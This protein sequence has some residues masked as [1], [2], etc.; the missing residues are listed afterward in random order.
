MHDD[1]VMIHQRDYR[2]EPKEHDQERSD[3][4][5]DKERDRGGDTGAP[6]SALGDP[7]APKNARGDS[8]KTRK[9]A[10]GDPDETRNKTQTQPTRPNQHSL[11]RLNSM[12]L[13]ASPVPDVVDEHKFTFSASMPISHEIYYSD[14]SRSKLRGPAVP[15]LDKSKTD[16]ELRK[17]QM[18][19]DGPLS[20]ARPQGQ[21]ASSTES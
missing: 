13:E 6:N 2:C 17:G 18:E 15:V 4:Q 21:G 8:G 10:H 3:G 20:Y 7:G 11:E 14:F 5:E 16:Y 9:S 1:P 12:A 19:R